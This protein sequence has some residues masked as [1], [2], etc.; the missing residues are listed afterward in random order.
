MSSYQNQN[1][2][3]IAIADRK[4]NPRFQFGADKQRWL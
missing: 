3:K 1:I 2:K 4:L